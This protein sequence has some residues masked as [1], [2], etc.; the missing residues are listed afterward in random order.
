MRPSCLALLPLVMACSHGLRLDPSIPPAPGE[1]KTLYA[2][3]YTDVAVGGGAPAEAE[4]CLYAHYTGWLVDGKKFDSSRDTTPDGKPRTPLAFRQGARQVI[5]GWDAGF[6]GMRV[7]GRRR[8]F[9]PYQ[10]AYGEKGRPPVIPAR[11]L[12]VFDVELMDVTDAPPVPAGVPATQVRC[13]A[14]A[15]RR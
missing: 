2:V 12:L 7:G 8:L 1:T 4:K 11:A 15:E 14:W 6:E 13:K 10:A 9:L 3:R 5:S